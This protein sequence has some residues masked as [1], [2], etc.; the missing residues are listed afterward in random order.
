MDQQANMPQNE[1][2]DTDWPLQQYLRIS[3]LAI[4]LVWSDNDA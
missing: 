3:L 1:D 4:L 2:E